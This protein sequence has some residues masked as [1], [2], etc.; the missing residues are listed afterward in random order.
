MYKVNNNQV[1]GLIVLI[2]ELGN[3]NKINLGIIIDIE[4]EMDISWHYV[5][6][7]NFL[8]GVWL[9]GKV[10]GC[11]QLTFKSFSTKKY[12]GRWMNR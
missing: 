5:V 10:L 9:R 3:N 2:L 4:Y 6:I 12:L 1:H 7:V 11:M 8:R